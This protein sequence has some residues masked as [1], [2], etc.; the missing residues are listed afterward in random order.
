MLR[1][2]R[3]DMIWVWVAVDIGVTIAGSCKC[4]LTHPTMEFRICLMHYL[5]VRFYAYGT[6]GVANHVSDLSAPNF[7]RV[8]FVVLDP[9]NVRDDQAFRPW[10]VVVGIAPSLLFCSSLRQTN[11]AII[12]ASTKRP[13]YACKNLQVVQ[14]NPMNTSS[15]IKHD[16]VSVMVVWDPRP[17]ETLFSSIVNINIIARYLITIQ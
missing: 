7:R 15:L 16:A 3:W 1:G 9:T 2:F 10:F 17:S 5:P 8:Q 12:V 13:A 4:E 14:V 6:I 11:K